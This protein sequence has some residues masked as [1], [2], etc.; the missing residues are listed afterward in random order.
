M[1]SISGEKIV[2]EIMID[3]VITIFI[4]AQN[5]KNG[6]QSAICHPGVTMSFSL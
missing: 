2:T 1:V 3:T 5:G 4:L 6:V